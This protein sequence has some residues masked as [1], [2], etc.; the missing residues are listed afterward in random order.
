MFWF[1]V[2]AEAAILP[3]S[4]HWTQNKFGVEVGVEVFL[5][6]R[7]SYTRLVVEVG[8]EIEVGVG[9]EVELGAS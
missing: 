8:V 4:L 7:S 1:S 5:I 3:F 6:W 2:F 9:V